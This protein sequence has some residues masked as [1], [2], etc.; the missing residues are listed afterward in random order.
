MSYVRLKDNY[1][2]R[3][4]TDLPYGLLDRES[5]RVEALDGKIFSLLELCNGRLDMRMVFLTPGQ[6]EMLSVL[7]RNGKVI[8]SPSP[9]PIQ[10]IQEYRRADNHYI[11]SVHWSITGRCNLKCRHCYMSAPDY[12]YKDLSTKECMN[13]IDQM[14]QANVAAV[15]ITGGEPFVRGDIRMLLGYLQKKGIK[16]TQIYTNG[17]LLTG[18][19][20]AGLKKTGIHPQFVLSFDGV[21]GH[22][23]LRGKDGAQKEAVSAIRLLK[24]YGFAVMVE[25]AIYEKNIGNLPET[26]ERLKELS[27]DYW[28]TSLIFPAGKWKEQMLRRIETKELYSAYLKLIEGYIADGAP[29]SLQ[30][31]GFFA[32]PKKEV[33]NWFSPYVRKGDFTPKE[34]LC[35]TTCRIQ[36][37]LLPDG[38]LLPCATMT[39]SIVEGEMP[40]L[41]KE[42]LAGIYQSPEHAFF[43]LVNM[44]T[45]DVLERDAKCR[46]CSFVKKCR[47]G[48]RAMSLAEGRG[49]YSHARVLCD[50]FDGGYE[51]LI[52]QTVEQAGKEG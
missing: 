36:P 17:L 1:A 16:V 11:R 3:G 14:E 48:C 27:V 30:L 5:G 29:F 24:E 38:T 39:D 4:F 25:T 35:C 23:W 6:R 46:T 43:K 28:K 49:L 41:Q 33:E 32:C 51:M 2:L 7:E 9:S 15:S 18:E 13:I 50:F 37:Y 26:Y 52:K 21:D 20:L 45:A 42:T 40:N 31:D 10:T 44:R 12:K 22:D 19:I 34:N 47:G 8:F